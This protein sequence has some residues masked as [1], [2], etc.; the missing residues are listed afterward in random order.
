MVVATGVTAG[1]ERE[2]LGLDVGDS[3]TSHRTSAFEPVLTGTEPRRRSGPGSSCWQ[4]RVSRT[5]RSLSGSQHRRPPSS[6]G[7]AAMSSGAW[8]GCRIPLERSGRPLE[9]GPP[10]DRGRDVEAA[11]QET[12]S[13]PLVEPAASRSDQGQP[14]GDP[15]GR[16]A[17][18][19]S[20]RGRPI[21]PVLHRPRVGREGHRHLRALS[22][23]PRPDPE[24]AIVL[25]VDEKPEI[26][27]LDRTVPILP[28]QE[29]RIERSSHA[30][31]ATAPPLCSPPSTSPP[32]TLP[33]R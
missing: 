3:V 9:A 12:R 18:M 21:V 15:S 30:T 25:C 16:G 1:G 2:I 17:R 27:A 32:V 19:G 10:Q 14:L 33:P 20:S 24:S 13:H 5:E 11:A 8:P 31:T 29:G 23:R 22:R 28:M 26:Q 4:L 6:S 7:V